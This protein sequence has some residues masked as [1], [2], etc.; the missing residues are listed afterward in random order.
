M[1]L[2]ERVSAWIEANLVVPV[3]DGAGRPFKVMPWQR[4]ALRFLDDDD[5]VTAAIS[6][7]RA[8]GKTSLL[9]A[10][11]VASLKCPE[12]IVPRSECVIVAPSFGVGRECFQAARDMLRDLEGGDLK[13]SRWRV[14]DSS[15][16]CSIEDRRTGCR[17][18]TLG[19]D[20]KRLHGLRAARLLI[21]DESA[22]LDAAKVDPVFV[23]LHTSVGKIEHA[24]LVL[25][26]TRPARPDHPF[27]RLLGGSGDFVRE[28]SAG[29]D[30]D[31]FAEASWKAANPSYDFLPTLRREIRRAAEKAEADPYSLIEF[32]ALRL[33]QGTA[34]V[35]KASLLE[36]CDWERIERRTDDLPPRSGPLVV[37]FDAGGSAAMTAAV[38]FWPETGRC[39]GMAAFAA[40]PLHHWSDSAMMG[41]E[42]TTSG[43]R[44][45]D[46][47]T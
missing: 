15:G 39:E 18:R 38:A 43:W 3:G 8:N 37:G 35:D 6:V 22:K 20:A 26:G 7:S 42:P 13:R 16:V 41:W 24:K 40:D 28:Y 21:L 44:S 11:A 25:I 9:A 27:S 31:P 30:D 19:S 17:V 47:S 1:R 46:R 33:N 32:R 4:D 5:C 10:L 36:L 2:S 29:P 34:E 14:W 12:F 23:A 45:R